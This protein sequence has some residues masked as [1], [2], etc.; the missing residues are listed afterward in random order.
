MVISQ[1]CP[2]RKLAS[3]AGVL[4]LS[5]APFPF[6]IS[7]FPLP[8]KGRTRRGA[9]SSPRRIRRPPPS[10]VV[11]GSQR[12]VFSERK[13]KLALFRPLE[14]LGMY[15]VPDGDFLPGQAW[16]NS[17]AQILLKHFDHLIGLE[18]IQRLLDL[19]G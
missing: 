5:P 19:H 3:A 18:E 2:S 6:S 13:F 8:I 10:L 7:C 15:G 4:P 12:S 16:L 14:S 9:G 11:N 17:Y 1:G